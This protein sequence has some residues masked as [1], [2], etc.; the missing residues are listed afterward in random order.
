M[1]FAPLTE[2]PA[3]NPKVNTKSHEDSGIEGIMPLNLDQQ[4]M[5]GFFPKAETRQPDWKK[6]S[7]GKE[8][9]VRGM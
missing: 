5:R 9:V 7:A 6:R 3:W 2:A 4:F 1:S 8:M